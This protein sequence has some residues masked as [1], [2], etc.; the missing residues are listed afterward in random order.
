MVKFFDKWFIIC[1]LQNSR[2][3]L[4]S[5][6]MSTL[7]IWIYYSLNWNPRFSSFKVIYFL[8]L[9][10]GAFIIVEMLFSSSLLAIVGAGEQVL[11]PF[12][13]YSVLQCSLTLPA[14]YLLRLFLTQ[15]PS[16]SPRRLCLFN[17]KTGTALRELNFLTSILAV[18][19]NRKR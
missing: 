5:Y 2:K 12:Y 7:E 10:I 14:H 18:R 8:C 1:L 3:E 17:T 15:Q 16:L 9:A 6:L 19:M 13:S 4:S 11:V